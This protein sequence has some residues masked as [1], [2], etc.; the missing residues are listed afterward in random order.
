MKKLA[1]L[2]SSLSSLVA[3]S[4]NGRLELPPYAKV[5][6]MAEDCSDHSGATGVVVAHQLPCPVWLVVV[7]SILVLCFFEE[8]K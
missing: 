1:Y 5:C 8:K 3:M 2:L 7:A 4:R 6:R